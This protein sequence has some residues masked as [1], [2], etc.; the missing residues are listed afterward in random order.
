MLYE[1]F[2]VNVQFPSLEM[3]VMVQTFDFIK[4]TLQKV[5]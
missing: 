2:A 5:K 1:M 3:S 4:L